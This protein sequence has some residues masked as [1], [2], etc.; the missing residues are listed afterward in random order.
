M[1]YAENISFNIENSNSTECFKPSSI[2]GFGECRIINFASGIKIISM[3]I[4][5]S[6]DEVIYCR[7]RLP[8]NTVI[9]VFSLKGRSYSTLH[10][11]GKILNHDTNSFFI[12]NLPGEKCSAHIPAG[13]RVSTLYICINMDMEKYLISADCCTTNPLW[14]I[15]SG[16]ERG[17]YETVFSDR[18]IT[19]LIRNISAHP[20]LTPWEWMKAESGILVAISKMFTFQEKKRLFSDSCITS[21]IEKIKTAKNILTEEFNK[22]ISIAELSKRSHINEFKLKK[23]FKEVFGN[24]VH[25]YLR[26]LR[27]EKGLLMI[28]NG[29]A[30]ITEAALETGFATPSS[31]TRSFR[32]KYGNS[33]KKYMKSQTET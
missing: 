14:R 32:G 5:T 8:E 26:D 22:N 11:T 31:F 25:E 17:V 13:E 15:F 18:S 30:N 10:D 33:P 29:E 1:N 9:G 23:G 6:E 16:A 20:P 4:L 7:E 12:G 3:D 24:T 2:N 19:D 21:D 28:K 27:L